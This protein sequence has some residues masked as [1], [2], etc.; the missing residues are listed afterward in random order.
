MSDY[1]GEK[2]R[3]Y[4]KQI[5][6]SVNKVAEILG[7]SRQAVYTFFKTSSLQR[8]TVAKIVDKLNV[9]E[10]EIWGKDSAK[11]EALPLRLADPYGFDATN[12]KI[13]KLPDESLIMQVPLIKE[14]AYA[15]YL[16]GFGDKEFYDDLETIPLLVDGVHRGSYI[17]FE[18]SGWSM[19]CYDTDELADLSIRPG[20]IAIGRDIPKDKWKYRLH[21]HTTDTWVIVHRTK[22]ILIKQ[23]TRHDVENGLI[24]IHSLN[25]E[26][27]DEDLD[28]RD[29]EQ[30]FSVVQIINKKR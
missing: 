16:V 30:I 23:I 27:K 3:F 14:K 22:G 29:V 5:G 6:L 26:F 20:R 25:P 12:E 11:L 21:T 4:L 2:F 13:Y 9:S 7:V 17:A 24:T 1:Q 8:E 15:G 28:L 18:V 10:E 19:V